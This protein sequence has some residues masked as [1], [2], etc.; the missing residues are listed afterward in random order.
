MESITLKLPMWESKGTGLR[1]TTELSPEGAQRRRRL[2]HWGG[3][4]CGF[5]RHR[6][7][8]CDDSDHT[9][10]ISQVGPQ[11]NPYLFLRQVRK[12]QQP[13]SVGAVWLSF[14]S[15]PNDVG[16][17]R[18]GGIPAASPAQARL[19]RSHCPLPISQRA[20]FF[21]PIDAAAGSSI[22]DRR[23]PIPKDR[24][25]SRLNKGHREVR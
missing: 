1:D 23:G 18:S 3:C 10:R 12:T 13:P 14:F 25:S 22:H 8:P 17:R 15:L 16:Y 20:M 11:L 24:T 2:S 19:Y 9:S 5:H 4:K 7:Q 21:R 6:R